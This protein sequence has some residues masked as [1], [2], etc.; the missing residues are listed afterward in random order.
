MSA[1]EPSPDADRFLSES[2]V[3]FAGHRLVPI[4]CEDGRFDCLVTEPDSGVALT[5]MRGYATAG[6]ALVQG[7]LW[8]MKHLK[9]D[10]SRTS[11]QA[12]R[13][14]RPRRER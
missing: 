6:E 12:P 3:L 7:Q 14:Q 10:L 4:A 13:L 11:L 2:T 9:L 8:L 1:P 5:R